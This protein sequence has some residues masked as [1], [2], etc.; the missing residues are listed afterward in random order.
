MKKYYT[1]RELAFELDMLDASIW[2]VIKQ[3]GMGGAKSKVYGKKAKGRVPFKRLDDSG[4]ER[5]K[6]SMLLKQVSGMHYSSIK[7]LPTPLIKT[8]TKHLS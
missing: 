5:I 3:L 6:Y 8:L 2:Y 1:V 7:E 4:L